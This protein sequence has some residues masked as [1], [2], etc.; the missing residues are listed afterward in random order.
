MLQL[1]A[2]IGW[3]RYTADADIQLRGGPSQPWARG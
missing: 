1:A 2:G 3:D